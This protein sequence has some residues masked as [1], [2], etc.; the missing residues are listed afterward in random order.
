[1]IERRGRRASA[2]MTDT[3]DDATPL[4]EPQLIPNDNDLGEAAPDLPDAL[5]SDDEDIRE[6]GI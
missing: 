5:E 3:E 4:A 1:M 2:V 6:P